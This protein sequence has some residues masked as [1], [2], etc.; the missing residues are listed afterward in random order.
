MTVELCVG[1]CKDRSFKYAGLEYSQE[2]KSNSIIVHLVLSLTVRSATA[3]TRWPPP[4][5][6]LMIVS[7]ILYA[8]AISV[9]T[10]VL[11]GI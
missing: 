10:V 11:E 3:E 2:V 5:P 6:R 8:K 7:A 1:V 4:Q 9:N